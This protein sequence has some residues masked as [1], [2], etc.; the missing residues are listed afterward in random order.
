MAVEERAADDIPNHRPLPSVDMPLLRAERR[1][2]RLR[3]GLIG[4][5]VLIAVAAGTAVLIL[6]PPAA[7]GTAVTDGSPE[8][9]QVAVATA[10]LTDAAPRVPGQARASATGEGDGT[11]PAAG[12]EP[13]DPAT[14]VGTP[15]TSIGAVSRTEKA[16]GQARFFREGLTLAGASAEECAELETALADLMDFRR[17]RPDDRLVVERDADGHILLFEYHPSATEYFQATRDGRGN[18]RAE[19]VAVPIEHVHLARGG[20]VRT[21]L[22]EALEGAGLH[23]SVVGMVVEAFATQVNFAT[24]AREGDSFRLL[25]DE[26][27]I[28]GRF[29]RYGKVLA[30]EYLGQRTGELRA[31]HYDAGDGGDFYDANGRALHGGWLRTP[32]RY[33]R[34]SSRFDPRRRHPILHRIVPHTGV[35][36]AAGTGTPVY[37]AANGDVSFAGERGANGNLV[38]LRHADGYESFYA[39]LHRI[40]R[41][42]RAGVHVRQRQLIGYVGSTGRSTGPHLHFGLKK[43]GSFMDPLEVINGPGRRLSGQHLQAF[44]EAARRAQAELRRVTV[45]D[46]PQPTATSGTAGADEDG[47]QDEATPM[48]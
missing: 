5:L 1:A 3:W 11:E 31:F 16:F 27:R 21:S 39:H 26:E 22:G 45:A 29:L 48:D 46:G 6:G 35:D 24:Q 17:C 9:D 7:E 18:L 40:E 25:V 14:S 38:A 41:G 15:P 42:I 34:I 12:I 28:D 19:R 44:R 32:V 47:H 37:A 10:A 13:P 33:D 2:L 43:N 8:P 23:R 20:R 36:Y 4:A 30:I